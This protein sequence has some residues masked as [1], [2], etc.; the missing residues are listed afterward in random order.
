MNKKVVM[1]DVA[2]E[3]NIS[4]NSV[5]RALSG[6]SGI[7]EKTRNLILKKADEMGYKYTKE[8]DDRTNVKHFAIIASLFAFSKKDFFGQIYSSIE[9][10]LKESDINLYMH[11]IDDNTLK[12]LEVP[13]TISEHSV[14][15]II[16][17]SHL[18]D[19]YINK[20]LSYKIPTVIIDYHSPNISADCVIAKN[21]EGAYTAVQY[22]IDH[23]H[24]EIGFIGDI[25]FSPSYEERWEGY[26]SALRKNNI[27]INKE[28]T[29]TKIREEKDSVFEKLSKLKKHPTCWFCVNS[30]L[31]FMLSLYYNSKGIKVPDDISILCFDNT[32]F[33]RLAMPPLTS[34]YTDL[35]LFGYKAIEMLNYRIYHPD[36]PF[37]NVSLPTQISEKSSVRW[38]N[39]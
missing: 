32:D 25:D 29:I 19:D 11:S 4:K 14:E 37:V 17:L 21:K 35:S 12:S 3:L 13:K 2:N 31:G 5:S 36:E 15:G 24:R 6:K 22:L 16:I 26:Q 34:V 30:G 7:S 27:N 8:N 39:K 10:K 33:T 28:Y 1:Q 9:N 23:N 38:L 18:T 20:I